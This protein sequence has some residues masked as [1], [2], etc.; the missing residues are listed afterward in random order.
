MNLPLTGSALLLLVSGACAQPVLL[1]APT[2]I[3]PGDV[4]VAGVPLA[5]AEITVRGTTLTVNGRHAIGS[6]ALER[7]GSTPAVLTHEANFSVDYG[8]GDIV[9][10]LHLIVAGSVSIQGTSGGNASRID[11]SALGFPAGMGPGAGQ[12]SNNGGIGAAG[13]A[14]GGNGAS[15]P[16]FAGGVG[17]GS[18]GQPDQF[19]SGGG[20]YVGAAAGRGGGCV[21][22]DV[23]GT[24]LVEGSI[25]ANGSQ[26]PSASGSGAGGSVWLNVGAISGVGTIAA[27]GAAGGANAW[28]GGG[29]GRIAIHYVSNSFAGTARAMG[30]AAS[31]STPTR[32]GAGT[33]Y[34]KEASATYPTLA[35]GAGGTA[36]AAPT[37]LNENLDFASTVLSTGANLV[38]TVPQ[39]FRSDV[40]LNGPARLELGGDQFINGDLTLAGAGGIVTHPAQTPLH[41]MIGGDCRIEAGSTASANGLGF[42]NGTGPGAG[43]PST[44][45]GIGGTGGAHGGN[46]AGSPPFA[47]GI[48][49]GSFDA[50]VTLGSGGGGYV[51]NA[52]GTGGGAVRLSVGGALTVDGSITAHGSA[53]ASSS[54]SGAGGSVYL[55]CGSLAGAGTIAAN[56]AVGGS[57]VWGGGGGGRVAVHYGSDSF[58]G[59]MSA[60][61]GSSSSSTPSRGGAGSIYTKGAA[62]AFPMLTFVA[63]GSAIAAPTPV[64]EN[65][66][67]VHTTVGNGANVVYAA[68]QTFR[69]DV[70][71]QGDCRVE[72]SGTQAIAGGLFL[73]GTGNTLTHTAENALA[74]SVAGDCDIA[75][76]SAINVDGLGFPGGAGPGAGQASNTGSFGAAGGGHG[77]NGASSNVFAG[78]VGY[79]DPAM[80]MTF[81]SGGGSF[82]GNTAG[83]GGGA[84]RLSVNGTLNVD[85]SISANGRTPGNPSGAGAGGS[86][87][88]TAGALA[89]GGT[90]SANG[91]TGGSNT[92]GGG[93][94]GR[95]AAYLDS[96]TYSGVMRA[97]GGVSSSSVQPR[98]GAGSVYV[99]MA[100][101]DRA[102]VTYDAGGTALSADTPVPADLN[103][104]DLRVAGGARVILAGSQTVHSD[105][106]LAAP[107]RLQLNGLGTSVAGNVLL[108]GSGSTLAPAPGVPS[109][110]AVGGDMTIEVGSVLNANGA[111]FPGTQ[112]PG[113]GQNSNTG[114]T[115]AAGGGYG[116]RGGNAN[117]FQG[118]LPYGSESQPF[119]MGSGGGSFVGNAAGAGGGAFQLE[120]VG[121]LDVL[122][123]ISANG[124]QPGNP[125][126]AGSGGGLMITAGMVSGS[127]LITANGGA[128]GSGSWGP[129]GGG[130]IAI[131]SCNRFIPSDNIRANGAGGSATAGSIFFGS[132]SVVITQNPIG[133][134]V[135]SG[136]FYQMGVIA[137]GDGSLAYQWRRRVADGEF[138]A[139][140]EGQD[141]VFFGVTTDTL[142]IQGVGC[143][144][145]GDYDCL[146]CDGCGCIPSEI[147]TLEIDPT[148]DYNDDGGIDGSDVDAFFFDWER[149]LAGADV[150]QDGGIDGGDVE[151]FFA[152]W[153]A[154]C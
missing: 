84:V 137:T 106:V 49:Y 56:G 75:G 133:G 144:G 125:S 41:L 148:G 21:H 60:T 19:G 143:A 83:A 73:T 102:D 126:G 78:G 57:N 5:T 113:A 33:V 104:R 27:D 31:S 26:G 119:Q 14:Y 64:P 149:G 9:S 81:G 43:Q 25:L 130:R 47:G 153:E 80:P 76:G 45:G 145:G 30:G 62:D 96:S 109:G 58:A 38:C 120:V 72:M 105:L 32:G 131:Y 79:G 3:N 114:S 7:S 69:G 92:W 13:G 42:P 128:G 63:G 44:N 112:G 6:L 68:G 12:A 154:G 140:T 134:P 52:G 65:L 101:E 67:A 124:E 24:L 34:M 116:G 23:S 2:T 66:N 61:G 129:G 4:V 138:I 36:I 48:A 100:S 103:A 46:G 74:L 59:S 95:I 115:G 82:I 146:V 122:G 20:S 55:T 111:G 37:V 50:P 29:G 136:G 22:L 11:V 127:G 110:L 53:G 94:G 17:Y 139:L 151:F 147:A 39:T 152:R 150:N 51:G 99:K 10:G 132:S 118:G 135:P 93:G 54:G 91:A 71:M 87:F 107:S 40:T 16:P 121:T 77:G 15:S 90:I 97:F 85:G 70:E 142:F 123:T 28:G 88:I 18:V 86:I 108:S 117:A 8:G 35:C 89:G 98:G 141:E 1:T